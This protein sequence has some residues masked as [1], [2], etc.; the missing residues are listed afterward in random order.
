MDW[1]SS[2]FNTPFYHILYKNR[3]DEEASSFLSLLINELSL[4]KDAM[5]MDLACG[6]GR[7]SIALN[8]FGYQVLGIDLSEESILEASVKQTDTLRFKVGDMRDLS[9]K[10]EFNAVFN[11]FTSIGYFDDLNDNQKVFNSV[12]ASLKDEGVFIIDFFNANNVI[13]NLVTH[14]IKEIDGIKFVINRKVVDGVIIKDISFSFE[15]KLHTYQEKVQ[16]LTY[17]D[18]VMMLDNSSFN[19][20][21]TFGDYALNNFDIN[22]S[23][24]LIIKATKK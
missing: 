21:K 15:G 20:E 14:E 9:I 2:W 6:K 18:F 24:R 23:P 5:V 12:S 19:V 16:A 7:H 3:N 8:Q 22:N 4:S 13:K 1:F 11:L 10:K 17:D